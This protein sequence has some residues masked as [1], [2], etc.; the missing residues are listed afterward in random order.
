MVKHKILI[1]GASGFIG[2]NLTR[3]LLKEGHQIIALDKRKP[4]YHGYR[5]KEDALVQVTGDIRDLK[6]LQKLFE[7]EID[8][9]IHLAAL[10]TIQMGAKDN[11]ETVSINVDGTETL[12]RAVKENGQ[13][14]GFLFASTDKVYGR[15]K[16]DA[17]TE[18]DSLNPIDSPYDCSKATADQMV[19]R[20]SKEQ[21]VHG[22]VL[23]FCN[24]YGKYDLLKTRIVPGTIQSILENRECVLR[25]YYDEKGQARNFRR[26]FLYV[27]DLCE[28]MGQ[29]I[30]KMELWNQEGTG[31]AMWGQ[32]FNLGTGTC[33]PMDEVIG[34]IRQIAGCSSLLKVEFVDSPAEI[35]RQKMDYTKARDTFGFVPQTS[36]REGLVQTVKWWEEFKKRSDRKEEV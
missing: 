21:G 31:S 17:Y 6:L 19:C 26:D 32:A 10:S 5:A 27:D 35:P 34:K 23:R 18:E 14:K 24:I 33:Y 16:G 4:I 11:E 15:L 7:G 1:T 20:W 12:L 2:T 28:A 3:Y 13:V 9:V 22:I 8:Y 36:L 29:I 30:K 25:V